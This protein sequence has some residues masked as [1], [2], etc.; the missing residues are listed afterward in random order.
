MPGLGANAG[1]WHEVTLTKSDGTVLEGTAITADTNSQTLDLPEGVECLLLYE[2]GAV[3][4]TTPTL[5][6]K[7]MCRLGSSDFIQYR[8]IESDVLVDLP[9][10]TADA[11]HCTAFKWNGKEMRI[12]FDVGGTTPSFT[13][14]KARLIFKN[15]PR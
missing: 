6:V 3:T 10:M 7:V 1:G 8:L 4:G 11:D 12:F 15:Y 5:D 9:Q 14:T 2:G 13:C